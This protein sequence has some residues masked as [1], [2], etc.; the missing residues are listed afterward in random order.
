MNKAK[1]ERLDVRLVAQGLAETRARAQALIMAGEVLVD[2][3]MKDKAGTRVAAD[4]EIVVK[5]RLPFVS[6]GGQKL[7]GALKVFGVDPAGL[8]ALDIG[9]STG[10]FSDCLLQAGAKKVYA[11]DVGKGLLA[12]KLRQ[13]AR[14]TVIEEMN[15]RS[16]DPAL[17][18]GPIEL[19]VV[20]VSFISLTLILPAVAPLLAPG[21][22]VLPLV[23]PQFE[24]GRKE[25]GKGGVVRD[26]AV[27][28]AAVDKVAQCA[29]SL[30]LIELARAPAVLKGPKG[31][32]EFFL[33]L[34]K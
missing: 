15:A 33:C 26:P 2:G 25:V 28:A 3:V 31:N 32:Q 29:R 5:A 30:G 19:A 4:A 22:L 17:F 34:R 11:V 14:V 24:A 16:L 23:K 8:V 12:A 1:T 21:A 10:G 7:A 9:S 20:D 18:P 13:D 27:I 6:R